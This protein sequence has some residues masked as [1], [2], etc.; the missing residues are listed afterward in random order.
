MLNVATCF[1]YT[2][3]CF[4]TLYRQMVARTEF[5]VQVSIVHAI[6]CVYYLIFIAGTIFIAS[7]TTREVCHM[8]FVV[9]Y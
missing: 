1:G 6:W 8:R 9:I 3:I 7:G 5:S 4:F 2:I